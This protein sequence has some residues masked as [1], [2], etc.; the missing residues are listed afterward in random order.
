[1]RPG[2]GFSAPW[3]RACHASPCKLILWASDTLFGICGDFVVRGEP[4]AL[5]EPGRRP[6]AAA[7]PPPKPGR[8]GT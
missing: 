2:R 7:A 1:M 4:S 5:A 8:G 3:G 6:P